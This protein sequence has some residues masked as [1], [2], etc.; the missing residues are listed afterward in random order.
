LG[1]STQISVHVKYGQIEQT[2]AGNVNDVWVSLNKFFGEMVPAFDI[3]RKVT[4]TVDLAK[5]VE[6]SKNVVAITSEGPE[7]LLPK[8]KLTD[9]ENLQLYLLAAYIGFK[10]GKLPREEMT[11]E[12]LAVKLG[13]SMKITTTRLGELTKDG[14]IIKTNEANYKITTIGIKRLQNMIL[15]KLVA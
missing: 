6:D 10:L 5:L 14:I 1:A 3:A 15:S 7:L 12:Q 13:K 4:L 11:K 9:R 8:E 2:F